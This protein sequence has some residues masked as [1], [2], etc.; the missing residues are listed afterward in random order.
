MITIQATQGVEHYMIALRRGEYVIESL[1]EWLR[2][3]EIDAGL[4]TSGIGS[5]E[6]CRLHTITDLESPPGERYIELDDRPLELA[7]MQG[8]VAGGEPH[9][10]IVVD[11]VENGTTYVGH[12]EPGSRCFA[13]LELGLIA[14]TGVRTARRVDPATGLIDIVATED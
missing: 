9:L 13:R 4:I 2:E 14:F 5:L 12:L 3:H 7:S 8:S 11:D 6:T 1:R 10:H